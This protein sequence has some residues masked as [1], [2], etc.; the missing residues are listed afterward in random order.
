MC[1][2]HNSDGWGRLVAA[3]GAE[4]WWQP[5]EE[6][7]Q[8]RGVGLGCWSYLLFGGLAEQGLGYEQGSE[9][10]PGQGE[11]NGLEYRRGGQRQG[12]VDIR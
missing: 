10:T 2:R 6:E 3:L 11:G 7:V 9:G 1:Q 5:A 12:I 4:R 8:G